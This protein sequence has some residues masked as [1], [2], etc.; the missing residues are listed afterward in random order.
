M[1]MPLNDRTEA[2]QALAEALAEY[3]HSDALVLA[4]PRGGVPVAAEIA[5]AL[6]AELDLIIV[7]KLGLPGHAELAMGAIASD[8]VRVLNPEIIQWHRVS[9]AEI[10]AVAAREQIE[11]ERRDRLYRGDRPH[12]ALRG[13]TV[14]LVDDGLATGATM[15]AA[16]DLVRQQAPREVI[17]AIPVAPADTVERLQQNVDRVVCLA[18]P[19]PF[20][21]IGR[22][23]RDFGQ[24]QDTEVEALLQDA[25]SGQSSSH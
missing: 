19:E 20:I 3:Q 14:I 5:R 9:M 16:V 15:Q 21:A 7:R 2:G 25:W 12:P 22:W 13:R 17:V 1:E 8:G 18:T 10:E 23:Y 11:L 6:N 4:L 24:T